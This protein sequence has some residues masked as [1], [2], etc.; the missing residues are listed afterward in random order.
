MT[1][2]IYCDPKLNKRL[3]ELRNQG[4]ISSTVAKKTD[5]IINRL[6]S[7]GREFSHAI[8]K[9]TKNGEW[10]IKNCKKYDLG[11]GYRLI[12]LRK[13]DILIFLYIGTHDECSRWLERNKGLQYEIGETRSDFISIPECPLVEPVHTQENDPTDEYERQLLQK[14]D[15]KTLRKIFCGLCMK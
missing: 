12:Y 7:R 3:D 6:I 4:G 13:E 10:R 15:D 9:H 14:I 11:N 8:G 5:G 1:L 2:S